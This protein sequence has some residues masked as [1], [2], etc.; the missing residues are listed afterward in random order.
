[1]MRK[2]LGCYPVLRETRSRQE[3]DRRK[4]RHG[5]AHGHTSQILKE[6]TQK[7]LKSGSHKK[8]I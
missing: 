2:I 3:K 7:N 8:G 1:M 4:K 5:T 6:D